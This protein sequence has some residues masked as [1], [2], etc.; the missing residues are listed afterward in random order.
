MISR[1]FDVDPEAVGSTI[2]IHLMSSALAMLCAGHWIRQR[3]MRQMILGL[4]KGI[5]LSYH[6]KETVL[7]TIDPYYGNLN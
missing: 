3:G 1:Q 6:N 2:Q 5:N 7:F 4:V